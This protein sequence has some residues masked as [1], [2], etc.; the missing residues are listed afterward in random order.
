MPLFVVIRNKSESD[1]SASVVN[2]EN[3]KDFP[4][5]GIKVKVCND[6]MIKPLNREYYCAEIF[7]EFSDRCHLDDPDDDF[8]HFLVHCSKMPRFVVTQVRSCIKISDSVIFGDKQIVMDPSKARK[9]VP[10]NYIYS[11]V[12]DNLSDQWFHLIHHEDCCA[13][14]ISKYLA[15]C[16]PYYCDGKN[17]FSEENLCTLPHNDNVYDYLM[18]FVSGDSQLELSDDCI[19]GDHLRGFMLTNENE[20]GFAWSFGDSFANTKDNGDYHISDYS[21]LLVNVKMS[22]FAL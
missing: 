12:E 8:I 3:V 4:Q 19:G 9:A 6:L 15:F 1:K 11:T 7:S 17:T 20:E 21:N 22:R 5:D 10:G 2:E 18:W 14:K 16:D 13:L